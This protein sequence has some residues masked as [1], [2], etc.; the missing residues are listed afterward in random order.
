MHT[1]AHAH[2]GQATAA[3][4]RRPLTP[5]KLT[6]RTGV[7]TS[8]GDPTLTVCARVERE[9]GSGVGIS[10]PAAVPQTRRPASL[11]SSEPVVPPLLI[12]PSPG[13]DVSRLTPPAGCGAGS[14]T[15]CTGGAGGGAAAAPHAASTAGAAP[16]AAPAAG[17]A[18]RRMYSSTLASMSATKLR[19]MVM[20]VVACLCCVCVLCTVRESQAACPRLDLCAVRCALAAPPLPLPT[21]TPNAPGLPSQRRADHQQPP[22]ARRRRRRHHLGCTAGS[23]GSGADRRRRAASD[24]T[25]IGAD[26]AGGKRDRRRDRHRQQQPAGRRH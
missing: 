3:H 2:I 6:W 14:S 9:R 16:A 11:A 12:A 22:V 8:T 17:G 15:T 20:V 10:G 25:S 5:P 13:V 7:S 4:S 23:A 26:G 24:R 21:C 1:A 19:L 18:A